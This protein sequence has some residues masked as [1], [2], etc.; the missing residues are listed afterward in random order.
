M[1]ILQ[2]IVYLFKK[3]S[4]CQQVYS[5]QY[6]FRCGR[7]FSLV[8]RLSRDESGVRKNFTSWLMNLPPGYRYVA[9]DRIRRQRRRRHQHRPARNRRRHRRGLHPARPESDHAS[10]RRHLCR[11]RQESGREVNDARRTARHQKNSRLTLNHQPAVSF[12]ICKKYPLIFI[13]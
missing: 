4:Y 3:W 13:L 1:N 11:Q 9:V 2:I 12:L 8:N 10:E 7:K 5:S 6:F